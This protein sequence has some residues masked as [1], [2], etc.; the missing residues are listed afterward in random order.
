[1]KTVAYYVEESSDTYD[2]TR[3]KI[4]TLLHKITGDMTLLTQLDFTLLRPTGRWRI[5]TGPRGIDLCIEHKGWLRRHWI[6]EDRIV[7]APERSSFIA[8]CQSTKA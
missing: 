3:L 6:H 1:M 4:A 2:M 7:F 5:D 8:T